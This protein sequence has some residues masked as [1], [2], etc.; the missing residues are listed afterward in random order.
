MRPVVL[1]VGGIAA[2][3]HSGRAVRALGV[4]GVG[5]A[6]LAAAAGVMA[7]GTAL[8]HVVGGTPEP[9]WLP[10][11]GQTTSVPDNR[12]PGAVEPR[13]GT[14]PPPAVVGD[15]A[16][17]PRTRVVVPPGS[18]AGPAGSAGTAGTV[19][20]TSAPPAGTPASVNPTPSPTEDA[21]EESGHRGR[22]SGGGSGGSDG[23]SSGSS[24]GSGGGSGGSGGS[25]KG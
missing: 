10:S 8:W 12:S 9:L 7:G 22:G 3:R 11:S 17:V 2:Q 15:S 5:V 18:A 19:G 13:R 25:G 6:S 4:L 21:G 20:T 24:G 14:S 1:R 16:P 23:G